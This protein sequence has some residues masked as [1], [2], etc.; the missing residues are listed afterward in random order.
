M[1]E[2]QDPE[3][4]IPEVVAEVR[5]VF[6]RYGAALNANDVAVLNELFRD[7]SYTVR[8]G[9]GENLY[10]YKEIAA[11]RAARVPDGT[12][13]IYRNAVITTFGR[14]FAATSVELHRDGAAHIGRQQQSWVRFAEGWRIV[15]AHVSVMS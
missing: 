10:G 14:D 5:A 12:L 13:R 4:N 2:G 8:F 15:A 7:A 11:F 3:I 1:A 6:D 9:I